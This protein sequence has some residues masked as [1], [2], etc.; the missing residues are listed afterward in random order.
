M[1]IRR[2]SCQEVRCFLNTSHSGLW[3]E[4]FRDGLQ[5]R[6]NKAF[7]CLDSITDRLSCV[8]YPWQYPGIGDKAGGE[9]GEKYP[10]SQHMY[11]KSNF[12]TIREQNCFSTVGIIRKL[13]I[14]PSC[15]SSFGRVVYCNIKNV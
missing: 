7:Y 8:I 13:Q 4:L 15:L 11:A 3:R 2:G 9:P 6:V 5:I 10:G 1:D 12:H 14:F